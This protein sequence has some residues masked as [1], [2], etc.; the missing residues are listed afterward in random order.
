[1]SEG[2][3]PYAFSWTNS[4]GTIVSADEDPIGLSAAT[5]SLDVTDSESCAVS[6]PN[7]AV[8]T[9]P[10]LLETSLT[11][12]DILCNGETNGTITVTPS[13]GTAPYTHSFLSDF[14]AVVSTPATGLSEDTYTVHTRDAKGCQTTGDIYNVEVH[15]P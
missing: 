5:Y 8:L 2:T 4:L 3:P 13:G 9:E 15:I 7:I 1:V 11:K 10:A 14:S 12:T 6:Y